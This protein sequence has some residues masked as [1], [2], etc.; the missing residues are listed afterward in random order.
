MAECSN[1]LGLHQEEL[2]QE[3]AKVMAKP[4]KPETDAGK[5]ARNAAKELLRKCG[6]AGNNAFRNAQRDMYGAPLQAMHAAPHGAATGYPAGT[7]PYGYTGGP[8]YAPGARADGT[9]VCPTH[10][11]THTTAPSPTPYTRCHSRHVRGGICGVMCHTCVRPMS[12]VRVC[13]VY[14]VGGM[15]IERQSLAEEINLLIDK[16]RSNSELLSDML[17]NS[18]GGADEF[19]K[20]LISDLLQEVR[21]TH[22]HT[23]TR[24]HTCYRGLHGQVPRMFSACASPHSAA[25]FLRLEFCRQVRICVCVCVCV[26]VFACVCSLTQVK[27]LRGLFT[28]YLEQLQTVD[29]EDMELL[30]VQALEAVDLLD[31]VIAL[32]KVRGRRV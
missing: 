23:H 28:A 1:V 11:H 26:C 7:M 20:E 12:C 27:E 17:V 6:R 13:V 29:G 21:E 9:Y 8:D 30:M 2:L 24:A 16:A 18:T 19:E 32:H 25:R 5:A 3:V 31:G 15:S 22:T 4:S 10:T 14:R